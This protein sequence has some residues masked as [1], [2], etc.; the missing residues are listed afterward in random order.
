MLIA[1]Y[2]TNVSQAGESKQECLQSCLNLLKKIKQLKHL[3]QLGILEVR[4]D[5]I[6]KESKYILSKL[7]EFY[8]EVHTGHEPADSSEDVGVDFYEADYEVTDKH[9]LKNDINAN[10]LQEVESITL[11]TKELMQRMNEIKFPKHSHIIITT[12]SELDN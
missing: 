2:F 5:I 3:N 8:K 12:R 10:L 11:K 6:V 9:S 1:V 7:D 4:P